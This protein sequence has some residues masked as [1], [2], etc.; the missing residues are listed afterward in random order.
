MASKYSIQ[1]S[2]LG[3]KK[4]RKLAQVDAV[5]VLKKVKILESFPV[6]SNN[7]KRFKGTNKPTYRFRIGNMRAIFEV[8]K[9]RKKIW[10]LAVGY[11]GDVYKN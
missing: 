11:R 3:I 9:K 5:K 4:L 6:E 2:N 10:V 1:F 8:H 7:I